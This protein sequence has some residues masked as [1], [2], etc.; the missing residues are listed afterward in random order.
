MHGFSDEQW[1]S[2]L[3][4]SL[5]GADRLLLESHL[6]AC[7]ICARRRR[8]LATLSAFLHTAGERLREG[9]DT[10]PE[11]IERMQS[12]LA[13]V[14][15]AGQ[16]AGR[17]QVLHS[18]DVLRSRLGPMCG[19]E[20]AER[21]IRLAAQRSGDRDAAELRDEHWPA[22]TTHLGDILAALCG[23]SAARNVVGLARS[24]GMEDAA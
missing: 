10:S 22:F 5:P 17:V 24:L 14:L 20:S 11:R 13:A 12:S 9:V 18:I 19:T 2:Y 4:G 16:G 23:T 3:E 6:K 1:A 7:G 8:D 15:R 21:V